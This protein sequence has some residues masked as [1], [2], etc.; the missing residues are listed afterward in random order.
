MAPNKPILSIRIL[1]QVIQGINKV[2]FTGAIAGA[3]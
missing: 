1:S 3:I 2:D